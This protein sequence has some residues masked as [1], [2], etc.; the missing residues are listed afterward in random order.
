MA[1]QPTPSSPYDDY[2]QNLTREEMD[3]RQAMYRAEIL[4][5]HGPE[6]LAAYEERWQAEF[7]RS[8]SWTR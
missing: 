3:E 6:A 1:T 5:E 8:N 2:G 7:E 4:A